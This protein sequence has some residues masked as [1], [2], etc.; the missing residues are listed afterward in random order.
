MSRTRLALAAVLLS[1]AILAAVSVQPILAF[2]TDTHYYLTYY[3]AYSVGFSP[4]EARVIASV[5]YAVDSRYYLWFLLP[6]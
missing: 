4:E 2:D 3:V 5:D 6:H 1:S